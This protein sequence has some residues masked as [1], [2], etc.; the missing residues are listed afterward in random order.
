MTRQAI[1][2]LEASD[3]LDMEAVAEL[4]RRIA[5]GGSACIRLNDDGRGRPALR[6]FPH[7]PGILEI[8]PDLP[9]ACDAADVP[10]SAKLPKM[11]FWADFSIIGPDGD[12]VG[13]AAVF[14]DEP[15]ELPAGAAAQLRYLARAF[16][17]SVRMALH[18][19]LETLVPPEPAMTQQCTHFDAFARLRIGEM[20]YDIGRCDATDRMAFHV[21]G[22]SSEW[23]PLM[24]SFEEGWPEIAAE[25]I[26]RT[27]NAT[28]DYIRMH[29]IRHREV[30]LPEGEREYD[31]YGILWRVRGTNEA[32]EVWQAETGWVEFDTTPILESPD[33]RDLA[34]Q[35]LIAAVDRLE[36]RIGQDVQGWARRLAQG[37]QIS[38]I[39]N[40]A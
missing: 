25:I 18:A 27:R 12:E 1:W 36:D 10:D 38:P 17:A 15:R 11:G 28:R 40:A 21:T 19:G 23:L 30:A 34:A 32:A 5:G 14:D 31:L 7:R 2:S 29:M 22:G 33:P 6:I 20:Q 35:A 3:P 9:F 4:A 24:R 39:L 13:F 26:A 37:A 16:S 8:G